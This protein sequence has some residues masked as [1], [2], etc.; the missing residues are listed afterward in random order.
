MG[1]RHLLVDD[2]PEMGLR[3]ET[4]AERHDHIDLETAASR[5][6]YG[7]PGLNIRTGLRRS[8]HEGRVVRTPR[9]SRRDQERLDDAVFLIRDLEQL[10]NPTSQSTFE[11][12]QGT[13]RGEWRGKGK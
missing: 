8:G 11:K 4:E 10:R 7:R 13:G 5:I 3:G 2:A 12:R 1:D 9:D 6:L